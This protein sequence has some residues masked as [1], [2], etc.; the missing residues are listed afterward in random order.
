M[1]SPGRK[2]ISIFYLIDE[3]L[4]CHPD[5]NDPDSY[6]NLIESCR[7]FGEAVKQ[8]LAML[9]VTPICDTDIPYDPE[10]CQVEPGERPKRSSRV[11]RILKPGFRYKGKVLEKAM[12]E[13]SD[14]AEK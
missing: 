14:K 5:Y 7:E 4:R 8:S 10:S 13:L 12:V 1:C 9:G 11:V 2:E 6:E 3:T